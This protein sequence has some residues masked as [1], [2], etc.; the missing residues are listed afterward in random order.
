MNSSDKLVAC[1]LF[2][3]LGFSL[4]FKLALDAHDEH[5]LKIKQ[6]N[7]NKQWELKAQIE[8]A[9]ADQAFYRAVEIGYMCS[10]IDKEGYVYTSTD[11]EKVSK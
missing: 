7:H 11:C 3:A 8:Q 1:V 6:E 9:K 5:M 4:V 2:M 10:F